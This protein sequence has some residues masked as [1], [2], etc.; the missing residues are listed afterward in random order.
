MRNIIFRGKWKGT[1]LWLCGDLICTSNKERIAILTQD[2][3]AAEIELDSIGQY[4]GLQDRDGNKIFEGDIIHSNGHNYLVVFRDGMFYASAEECDK[5]IYGGYPLHALTIN[6][7]EN[8]LCKIIGN[9]FD[10][11]K[12]LINEIR[13]GRN[14]RK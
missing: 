14:K 10:N 7:D 13:N 3:H 4:T 5:C 9:S 11:P 1:N 2:D 6:A 12:L 8:C